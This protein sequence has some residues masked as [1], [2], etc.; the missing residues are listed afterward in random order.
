[1]AEDTVSL[2]SARAAE[3][4]GRSANSFEAGRFLS[5]A[6]QAVFFRAVAGLGSDHLLRCFFFGGC[7]GA[8]RRAAVFFPEWADLSDAPPVLPGCDLF[9]PEREEYFARVMGDYGGD[10]ITGI[11]ALRIEGSGYR[12]LGHRDYMGSILAAGVDRSVV[13]DIVPEGDFSARVFVSREIAPYLAA[14]LD[15]IGSDKVTVKETETP[16]DF[17]IEKK[18]ETGTAVA[19]SLRLDAVIGAV[20]D[21]GRNDAR[22]AVEGG[23]CSVNYLTELKADRQIKEGDVISL[24]GFGKIVTGPVTGTTRSGKLRVEYK[25]Y[26]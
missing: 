7:R 23:R 6:E 11:A 24:K 1:M 4:A 20:A 19:A 16:A 8:E 26:I 22:E 3:L 12:Q 5:P 18:Y 10:E 14:N 2:I 25:K 9:S 13:G 21:L 17:V 15:R